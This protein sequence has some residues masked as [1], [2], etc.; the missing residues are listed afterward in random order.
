MS[1]K[2]WFNKQGNLHAEVVQ[3]LLKKGFSKQEII[4]YF[5]F[6]NM[7]EKEPEFCPLY[8]QKKKC[9]NM[10]SLN[11]FL[12]ACPFFRFK[13]DG[14]K[15]IGDKTQYSF[16]SINSKKG[17]LGEYGDAIHQDCSGCVVPHKRNFVE[18]HY[19]ENWFVPM[20]DCELT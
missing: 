12:C 15:K 6:D 11:C 16:C 20:K 18:K 3:R 8:A 1:Y 4:D 13:N 14:L 7:I 10:E 2:S 19:D 9:H 5:N 17:S